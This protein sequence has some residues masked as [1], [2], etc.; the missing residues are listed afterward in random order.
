MEN[1]HK[2]EL[3]V[4]A[5]MFSIL[6]VGIGFKAA[7]WVLCRG[8]AAQRASDSMEALA[9]DFAALDLKRQE[10]LWQEVKRAENKSAP[11]PIS[12]STAPIRAG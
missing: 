11:A 3:N 9:E 4:G 5:G 7:L 6:G 8:A 1:G 12:A 10:A 2:P